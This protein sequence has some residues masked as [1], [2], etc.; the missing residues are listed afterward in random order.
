MSTYRGMQ[1]P[2]SDRRNHRARTPAVESVKKNRSPDY[3]VAL[4]QKLCHYLQTSIKLFPYHPRVS[5]CSVSQ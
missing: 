1:R 4:Q 3:N 5:S 2:N